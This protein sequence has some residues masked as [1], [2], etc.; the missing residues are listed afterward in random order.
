[1]VDTSVLIDMHCGRIVKEALRL[2]YD[3]ICPDI[4]KEELINPGIQQ[5]K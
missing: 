3:F 4:I 2:Q 1:V 5:F